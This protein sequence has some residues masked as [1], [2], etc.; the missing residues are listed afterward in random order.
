M[1]GGVIQREIGSGHCKPRLVAE[2]GVCQCCLEAGD[3]FF[4]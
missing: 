1:A 3:F 4:R 2:L